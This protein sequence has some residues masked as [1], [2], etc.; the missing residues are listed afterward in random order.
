V[1]MFAHF[2][3]NAKYGLQPWVHHGNASKNK[4]KQKKEEEKSATTAAEDTSTAIDEAGDLQTGTAAAAAVI[5]MARCAAFLAFAVAFTEYALKPLCISTCENYHRGRNCEDSAHSNSGD[6][7]SRSS[8]GQSGSSSRGDGD[9]S[10][11]PVGHNFSC[12]DGHL[13]SAQMFSYY[14]TWAIYVRYIDKLVLGRCDCLSEKTRLLRLH[15]SHSSLHL[16]FMKH[17]SVV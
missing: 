12:L 7:S 5:Q 11:Y 1:L 3:F 2:L 6:S 9:G 16:P 14:V 10:T 13:T 15:T 17:F 4:Q 8:S